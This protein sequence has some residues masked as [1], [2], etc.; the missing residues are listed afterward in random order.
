M[1]KKEESILKTNHTRKLESL[2]RQYVLRTQFRTR[3]GQNRD[4]RSLPSR[5]VLYLQHVLVCSTIFLVLVLQLTT[6][7]SN[8]IMKPHQTSI[9]HRNLACV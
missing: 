5:N 4:L 6:V 8:L 2:N 3:H 9:G 1:V 7:S